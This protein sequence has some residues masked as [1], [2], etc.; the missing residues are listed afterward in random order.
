MDRKPTSGTR[1]RTALALTVMAL[2]MTT[3]SAAAH[4]G[5]SLDVTFFWLSLGVLACA[6]GVL[7]VDV[8][9]RR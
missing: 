1:S 5:S 2:V 4:R 7:L 9:G 3:V 6:A 8:L